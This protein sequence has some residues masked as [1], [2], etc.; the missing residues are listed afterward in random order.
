MYRAVERLAFERREVFE[1]TDKLNWCRGK[2]DG[3]YK[4]TK[5]TLESPSG[6][7]QIVAPLSS[8]FKSFFGYFNN[9]APLV[10]FIYYSQV[11]NILCSFHAPSLT[12]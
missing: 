10:I 3:M 6:A 8:R 2:L 11:E 1:R 12:G 4:L 9:L 7:F 5:R